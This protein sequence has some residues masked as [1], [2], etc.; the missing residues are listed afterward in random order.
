MID[1]NGNAR[2]LKLDEQRDRR[3]WAWTFLRPLPGHHGAALAVACQG[4]IAVFRRSDLLRTRTFAGHEADV[5]SLAPSPDGR[6]L[7][8]GSADQTARLWS[9]AGCDARPPLG[10]TFRRDP[11]GRS[12]VATVAKLGFAEAMGLKVGDVVEI[13][14]VNGVRREP[15]GDLAALDNEAPGVRIEFQVRRGAEAV[16]VGTT[17]RDSP[18]LSLFVGEDREWVIWMPEGYYDTSAAGDRAYLGWHR[19]GPTADS[20]TDHFSAETFEKEFRRPD[21]LARLFA[22]ADPVQA[23]A[24][25]ANPAEDPPAIVQRQGPPLLRITTTAPRPPGRPILTPANSIA[26]RAQVATEDRVPVQSVTVKVDGRSVGPPLV[27]NP[28]RPLADQP[29]EVPLHSGMQKVTVEAV[30]V[31][32]KTRT[33]G[34]E[35]VS[36]V[37]PGKAPTLHILAI[38]ASSPFQDRTFPTIALADEDAKDVAGFLAAPG[39]ASK[40]E[41]VDEKPPIVGDDLTVKNL[42]DAF[43]KLE[44][45]VIDPAD[46]VL[47]LLETHALSGAK[48]PQVLTADAGPGAAPTVAEI[49]DSL[50]K[51][52]EKGCR[53]MVLLDTAHEG[54]QRLPPRGGRMGPGPDPS[55]GDRLRRL[56]RG[57]EPSRDHFWPRRVRPGDPG[58]HRPERTL[59]DLGRSRP[60]DDPRRLPGRRPRPGLRTHRAQAVRRVLPARDR[61]APSP[62]L[63]TQPPRGF[64]SK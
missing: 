37:P 3:W 31:G 22:T 15:I 9:L 47:I 49:T 17:R 21:I 5:L 24:L 18:A 25:R 14:A 56:E 42:R 32:G 53:V 16:Q 54:A 50:G 33:D 39:G 38:G 52:A 29:I 2:T 44:R 61:L 51:I 27:F 57:A 30:N 28:P 46:T 8:S 60:P 58:Q 19:N 23:L 35:V 45:D 10:A 48:T 12:V 6:W 59:P 62:P 64:E 41:S 7:L 36:T 11:A 13:L 55:R 20:P 43:R 26:V 4:G 1:P 40:F 34:F 63:R